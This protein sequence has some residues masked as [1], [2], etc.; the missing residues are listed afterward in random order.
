[1]ATRSVHRLAVRG[2]LGA[3]LA[4]VAAV[5][6]GSVALAADHGV[7]IA[8][9]AF[10]PDSIT[11]AV[12]DMIT[13]TNND[14]VGHTA[15]ADDASFDTGTIA[16]GSSKSATFATAGT[17]TYHCKIHPA[18]AATIVVTSATTPPTTDT[19][20]PAAPSTG[21]GAPLA[22]LA[23]AGLAGLVIGRR[24]FARPAEATTAV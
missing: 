14:G 24:R 1:M 12:G 2:A 19:L 17:F 21:G 11:I 10:S 16:A 8:G 13:W 3:I 20:D 15:T 6:V 9:F 22:L 18:M 7:A 5:G 23:L 4:V